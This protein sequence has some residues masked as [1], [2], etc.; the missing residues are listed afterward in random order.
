MNEILVTTHIGRDLLQ[1]GSVFKTTDVAVWE[2]IVNSLQYIS[3]G[4]SPVVTIDINNKQKKITITDNGRGMDA[5]GLNNFFTMH[6]ENID[7][8][9]GKTG[10]GKFGTGKSAA[11]GI[12]KS[13]TVSSICRGKRNTVT[14]HRDNIKT[15]DGG[16]IPVRILE[17][18]IDVNGESSGTTIIIEEIF[19][20][21]IDASKLIK[22]IEKHLKSFRYLNPQVAVGEHVCTYKNPTIQE[23]F[24]FFPEEHLKEY[25]G[26]TKL[27]INVSQAPLE[28]DE[29]GI[30]ISSGEGNLVAVEDAGV[31]TKDMGEYLFG[32]INVSNLED[33]TYEM[34]AFDSSRDMK[35]RPEHPVVIALNMLIG[36]SLE[37]VRK[38]LVKKKKESLKSEEIK[39]LKE[40]ADKIAEILNQDFKEI[41]D[42]ILELRSSTSSFGK[43]TSKKDIEDGNDN[44]ETDGWVSGIEERGVLDSNQMPDLPNVNNDPNPNDNEKVNNLEDSDIGSPN[45]DGN[46]AVDPVSSGDKNKSRKPK[47]GF[48]VE[49]ENM[50]EKQDRAIYTADKGVFTVN[51]DHPVVKCALSSLGTQ[52]IGFIRLSHEIVFSEYA[53]AVANMAAVDDPDIPADDVIYDARETLNRIS[54]KSA[55]LYQ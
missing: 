7:R 22:K 16:E 2:Y 51:L 30:L 53:L 35:L 47:G 55:I 34:D 27:I 29:R 11:F 10:R 40:Q 4:V 50:G 42:K 31:C 3:H 41:N 54:A 39:K 14:L 38:S 26:E 19:I 21:K 25:L 44:D 20:P 36:S 43:F 49:Y 28:N 37:E 1:S 52:D 17:A 46:A 23:C 12:A 13:L 5:D 18:D 33:E 48:K 8:K 24:E 9:E 6:G 45:L 32:E 15:S